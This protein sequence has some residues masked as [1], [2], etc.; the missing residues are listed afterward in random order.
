[1]NN[2]KLAI[3]FKPG[4]CNMGD[5]ESEATMLTCV[6]KDNERTKWT[7]LRLCDEHFTAARNKQYPVSPVV[8]FVQDMFMMSFN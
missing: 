5:H 4:L 2:P 3:T 1:M 6:H 7:W 8:D